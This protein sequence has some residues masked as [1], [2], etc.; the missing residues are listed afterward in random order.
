MLANINLHVHAPFFLVL[1]IND[2]YRDFK[3]VD[4]QLALLIPQHNMAIRTW[5]WVVFLLLAL[6]S[7]SSSCRAAEAPSP[8]VSADADL[9]AI[10]DAHR[11]G[12]HFQPPKNWINGKFVPASVI[13]LSISSV[14][15]L[16][17]RW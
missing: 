2:T 15:Q 8:Q 5:A 11:T 17:P 4:E 13:D 3:L 6:L 16:L 9:A 10:D 7:S 14:R 1:S 12:Y